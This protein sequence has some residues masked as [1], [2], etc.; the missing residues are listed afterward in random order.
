MARQEGTGPRARIPAAVAAATAAALEGAARLLEKASQVVP[1]R[2]VKKA[3]N[4][5]PQ[6]GAGHGRDDTH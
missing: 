6:S 3:E 1:L 4:P 2:R 5:A